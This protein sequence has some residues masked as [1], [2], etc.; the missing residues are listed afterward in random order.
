MTS[1]LQVLDASR[2]LK[3]IE[4]AEAK[5]P[6]KKLVKVSIDTR[7]DNRM[8]DLRT[9]AN[10]AIMKINA[11]VSQFFREF[12]TKEGFT[13]IHSP[14]IIAGASEGGAA[15]FHLQYM[16]KGPA[17]LAQ[18]PQL[19]KQMGVCC[20]LEKVFEV[21][22]VFRAENSSTNRHLCEYTGLDYEMAFKDHY[23][24]SQAICRCV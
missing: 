15:V 7:L 6:T 4:D 19:Y 10:Q 16:D 18:S 22:P 2:S 8:V 9:P 13:E 1:L 12:L 24:S 14:K 17:C 3:E 21:A 23:V 20:D 5:D 11:G